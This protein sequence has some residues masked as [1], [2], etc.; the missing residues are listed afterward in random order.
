MVIETMENFKNNW[1]EIYIY[2]YT[3]IYLYIY[4]YIY[5]FW[6]SGPHARDL[7]VI[8][9]TNTKRAEQTENHQLF[10]DPSEH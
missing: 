1:G 3:H 9:F 4:I 7:V 2:I 8:L 5:I 6:F 10:L